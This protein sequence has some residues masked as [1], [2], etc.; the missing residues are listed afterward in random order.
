[1]VWCTGCWF[2]GEGNIPESVGQVSLADDDN[3]AVFVYFD[4]VLGEKCDTIVV[5]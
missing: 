4:V 5:A 1:M 2:G 3:L